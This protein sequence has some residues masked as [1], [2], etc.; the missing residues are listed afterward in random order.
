[1]VTTDLP[2]EICMTHAWRAPL[3]PHQRLLSHTVSL[4]SQAAAEDDTDADTEYHGAAALIRRWG[5]AAS[6]QADSDAA[7]ACGTDDAACDDGNGACA[8]DAGGNPSSQS[9]GGI[10][11]AAAG[12]CFD[13]AGGK[14]SSGAEGTARHRGGQ[15]QEAPGLST[16]FASAKGEVLYNAEA[17]QLWLLQCCQGVRA[18]CFCHRHHE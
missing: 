12:G 10:N 14:P 9:E 17:L 3:A 16:R 11:A 15:Q 2:F 13:N 18:R 6:I 5:L 7:A 8:D 4:R 1:M